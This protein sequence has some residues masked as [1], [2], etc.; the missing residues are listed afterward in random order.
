MSKIHKISEEEFEELIKS[1]A[2]NNETII[3]NDDPVLIFYTIAKYIFQEY[4]K[5]FEKKIDSFEF[6]QQESLND[7]KDYIAKL[8]EESKQE[9]KN[10]LVLLDNRVINAANEYIKL[11]LYNINETFD[12]IEKS[13]MKVKNDTAT[14]SLYLKLL[15]FGNIIL[16]VLLLYLLL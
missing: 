1:I 2:L 11:V 16:S 14:Q 7:L 5:E 12:K 10:E 8:K 13:N 3:S 15:M 6:N 4:V 9:Y